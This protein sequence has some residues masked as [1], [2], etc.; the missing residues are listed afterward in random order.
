MTKIGKLMSNDPKNYLK[1]NKYKRKYSKKCYV[2]INK[3]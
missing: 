2:N 1:K 3:S